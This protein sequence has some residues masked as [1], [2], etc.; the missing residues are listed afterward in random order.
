MIWAIHPRTRQRLTGFGIDV[1]ADDLTIVDPLG[2]HD[3]VSLE[4]HARCVLSDSGTVQ[5][6]CCIMKVPNV[7][8]RDV[9]ERPETVECG[10]NIL[11]GVEPT[12]VLRAVAVALAQPPS[13]T[14]PP[15][16]L[17][18][19]VSATVARIVLGYRA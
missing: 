14:P 1:A 8:L 18:R 13:W 3:F 12:D 19:S 16:Y 6:E 7:T 4:R 17:V 9:T 5:E 15:E 11:A 2:L 10:S